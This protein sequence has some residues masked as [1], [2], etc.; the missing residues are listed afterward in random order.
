MIRCSSMLHVRLETNSKFL[1]TVQYFWNSSLLEVHTR[2]AFIVF[3]NQDF[4]LSVD[5]RNAA[6]P[7][8]EFSVYDPH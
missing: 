1:N 6:V 8:R 3:Q 5:N 7:R 4:C 2:R